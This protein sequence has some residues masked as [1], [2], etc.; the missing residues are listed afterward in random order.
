LANDEALTKIHK[1]LTHVLATCPDFFTGTIWLA[2]EF[3]TAATLLEWIKRLRWGLARMRHE[4]ESNGCVDALA[5]TEKMPPATFKF[6]AF[7]TSIS[8]WK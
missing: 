3:R 6:D 7:E 8:I 4:I 1:K 5:A 2:P